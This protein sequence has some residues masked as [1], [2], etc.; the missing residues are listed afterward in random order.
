MKSNLPIWKCSWCGKRKGKLE[1]HEIELLEDF[2]H[3]FGWTLE[4]LIFHE[5]GIAYAHCQLPALRQAGASVRRENSDVSAVSERDANTSGGRLLGEGRSA[6]A[7]CGSHT[8]KRAS[9]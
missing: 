3:R 9:G 1:E 6:V 4:P 5:D 8:A 7:R 2:L